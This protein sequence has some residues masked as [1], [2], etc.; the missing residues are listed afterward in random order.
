MLVVYFKPAA[1][2]TPLIPTDINHSF[3]FLPLLVLIHVWGAIG[4]CW[5]NS[6]PSPSITPLASY[7]IS[8]LNIC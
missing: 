4:V 8:R 7:V 5:E 1:G 2:Q 3:S 6:F